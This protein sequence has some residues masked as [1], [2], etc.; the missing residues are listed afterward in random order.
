MSLNSPLE[1]EWARTLF[2]AYPEACPQCGVATKEMIEIAQMTG[3]KRLMNASRSFE[4][5]RRCRACA[6]SLGN[7]F[8]AAKILAGVE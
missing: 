8:D 6:E 3:Q 5:H 7:V 1:H 4:L 2:L